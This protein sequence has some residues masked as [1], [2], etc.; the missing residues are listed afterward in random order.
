MTECMRGTIPSKASL[1]LFS[2][3]A[4]S[5]LESTGTNFPGAFLWPLILVK[6]SQIMSSAD[7]LRPLKS[8]VVARCFRTVPSATE[9]RRCSYHFQALLW[10]ALLDSFWDRSSTQAQSI[11]G[12]IVLDA[13]ST[14]LATEIW[15]LPTLETEVDVRCFPLS[16][17]LGK[18]QYGLEPDTT[19]F[20]DSLECHIITV[21]SR[22]KCL[23]AF[24]PFTSPAWRL[25]ELVLFMIPPSKVI[26]QNS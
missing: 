9:C 17:N 10:E 4:P 3:V 15:N 2:G 23:L 7:D 5:Q 14:G 11:Q 20:C 8:K 6:N 21:A 22:C 18:A 26:M 16:Y 25:I 1:D 24:I 19:C 13:W 12:Y